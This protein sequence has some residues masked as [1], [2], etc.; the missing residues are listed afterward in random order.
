MSATPIY[1]Y[2]SLLWR[3]VGS[4]DGPV[5]HPADGARLGIDAQRAGVAHVLQD[6]DLELAARPLISV[7]GVE[8]RILGF[9]HVAVVFGHAG[10][11]AEVGKL[12]AALGE[13]DAEA[14]NLKRNFSR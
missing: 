12:D 8:E 13:V 11:Q 14:L 5:H 1:P 9:D 10:S 3:I 2:L 4:R 7:L 6:I